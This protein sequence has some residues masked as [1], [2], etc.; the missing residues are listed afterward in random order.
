MQAH[1]LVEELLK[2]DLQMN[3]V[4]DSNHLCFILSQYD[5]DFDVPYYAKHSKAVSIAIQPTLDKHR[6]YKGKISELRTLFRDTQISYDKKLAR[7]EDVEAE[8]KKLRSQHR[9]GH[10]KTKLKRKHDQPDGSAREFH[11]KYFP[12]STLLT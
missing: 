1:L 3:G 12:T 10:S 9:R 5:R 6:E 8:I 7:I 4:Y 2:R 11:L